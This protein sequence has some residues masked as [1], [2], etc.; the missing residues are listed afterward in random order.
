MDARRETLGAELIDNALVPL[1]H[2]LEE[3][4]QT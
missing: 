4:I 3:L 2:K 1:K